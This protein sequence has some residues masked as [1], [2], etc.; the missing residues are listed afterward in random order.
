VKLL[1]RRSIWTTVREPSPRVHSASTTGKT[2]SAGSDAN[3]RERGLCRLTRLARHQTCSARR[4]FLAFRCR[5]CIHLRL[6]G[7]D[8]GVNTR[9]KIA[10]AAYAGEHQHRTQ[11]SGGEPL[12]GSPM[13]YTRGISP[14]S[15]AHA[16][17]WSSERLKLSVRHSFSACHARHLATRRCASSGELDACV[18]K[19]RRQP[20]R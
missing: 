17:W 20:C 15:Q 14:S 1:L 7:V 19:G 13:G 3:S 16:Q 8:V 5:R 10:R 2:S 9:G 18:A 4:G 11:N 6:N 12:V